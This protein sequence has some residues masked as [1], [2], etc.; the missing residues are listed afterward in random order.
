[1][2]VYACIHIYIF[3]HLGET[4]KDSRRIKYGRQNGNR[5]EH[6]LESQTTVLSSS[7]CATVVVVVVVVLYGGPG[8]AIS[9]PFLE[10]VVLTA[11]S[12]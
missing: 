1:M 10:N 11:E 12:K 9:Q 4:I 3:I 6:E 5:D 7:P 8:I 2:T